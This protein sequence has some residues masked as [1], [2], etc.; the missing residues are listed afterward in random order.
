MDISCK[1]FPIFIWYLQ[2]DSLR[3]LWS[4]VL[5]LFLWMRNQ[6]IELGAILPCLSL[7]Y[8]LLFDFG[9]FFRFCLGSF[10]FTKDVIHATGSKIE[11]TYHFMIGNIS[12]EQLFV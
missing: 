9:K 7:V 2:L 5:F 3:A 6:E 11:F 12:L 10:C 4:I 1:I 8:L